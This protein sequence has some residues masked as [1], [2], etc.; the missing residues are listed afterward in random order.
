MARARARRAGEPAP[1]RAEAEAAIEQVGWRQAR[2]GGRTG[3]PR[4]VVPEPE[5]AAVSI[6]AMAGHQAMAGPQGRP[7]TAPLAPV[8]SL[9]HGPEAP[10]PRPPALAAILSAAMPAW[11]GRA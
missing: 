10:P 2:R 6:M 8:P 9:A 1:L 11:C 3:E 7:G 4:G 5:P